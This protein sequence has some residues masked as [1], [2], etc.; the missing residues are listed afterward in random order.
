MRQTWAWDHVVAG[1]AGLWAKSLWAPN[2]ER[3]DL[4]W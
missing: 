3:Q 1:E 2:A 4:S